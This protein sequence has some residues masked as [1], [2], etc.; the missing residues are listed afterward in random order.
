[1]RIEAAD[2]LTPAQID[3][4]RA[5]LT[6]A[7]EADGTAPL[8]EHVFLHLTHGGD[9]AD[10]HLLAWH[11]STL[12]AYA[13]LDATDLVAGPSA[14][15]VVHPQHRR[16]GIGTQLVEEL[17]RRSGGRLRL[18]AHGLHPAAATL[19]HR[20][21]FERSRVLWQM[22]RSLLTPL[23]EPG[24]P[25]DVTVRTFVVGEDEQRWLELNNR[26][27]AAHPE[28]GR[29]TVRDVQQREAEDWFDPEGFFLAERG[30]KLVAFHWTKVH[31]ATAGRSHEHDPIGEVY[32]LGVDPEEAG[33]GLGQAMTVVGLRHLRDLGLRE[34]ML[35]VDDDNASAVRLYERLGFT[36]WDKDVS[37]S[38]DGGRDQ[39]SSL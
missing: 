24:L 28:Q 9:V 35:Y 21:G 34:V 15:L 13:H 6:A 20:L 27:F 36:K 23:P 17:L 11:D 33:A 38:R 18:W 37:F 31:G 16:R 4:V 8:S 2:R 12:A 30:D 39:N 3:A 1:M 5:V 25:S 19:A 29:W 26:A 22:R 32:V 7:T 10:V 14:E